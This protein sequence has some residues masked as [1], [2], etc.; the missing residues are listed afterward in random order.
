[1]S[2]PPGTPPGTQGRDLFAVIA[3]AH[4]GTSLRVKVGHY[5]AN[6]RD[7]VNGQQCHCSD[8]VVTPIGDVADVVNFS[9][10]LPFDVVPL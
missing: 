7:A 4:V 1:M 9:Y 6:V 5:T 2:V 8:T 10:F 3:S